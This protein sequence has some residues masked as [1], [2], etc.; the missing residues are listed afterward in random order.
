MKLIVAVIDASEREQHIL[1]IS[2]G[3][4]LSYAATDVYLTLMLKK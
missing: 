3:K 2:A 4:Q 1:D